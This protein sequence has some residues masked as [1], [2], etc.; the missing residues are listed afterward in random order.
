[1]LGRATHAY[2]PTSHDE[3]SLA[4]GDRCTEL[5]PLDDE[6]GWAS[7]VCASGSG[8][9]P[10]SHVALE[11][12][13][14]DDSWECVHR[15]FRLRHHLPLGA[16]S[17]PRAFAEEL[18]RVH[19]AA[20]ERRAFSAPLLLPPQAWPPPACD[21]ASCSYLVALAP[22]VAPY[23]YPPP[24]EEQFNAQRFA[25]M[26]L[27]WVARASRR[28]LVEPRFHLMPRNDT[29][30][31]RGHY[32][33]GALLGWRHEPATAFFNASALARYV[34]L[35]SHDAF[36]ERRGRAVDVLWRL[37]PPLGCA[38]EEERVQLQRLVGEDGLEAYGEGWR[39][40]A[41]R[42]TDG[43]RRRPLDHYFGGDDGDGGAGSAAAV[44]RYRRGWL[45]GETV[46]WPAERA[47]DYAELRA[48][49]VFRDE[50]RAAAAE[51]AA[52][53]LHGE[54]Y[55][56]VH[57]R[58]GDRTH[59]EMG[60]GGR[61]SYD[62]VAPPR[63]VRFVRR[64]LRRHPAARRVLLL[65]NSGEAAERAALRAALP[66]LVEYDPGAVGLPT[67][68]AHAQ[69]HSIVE[70][71][72]GSTADAFLAGPHHF[73]RLSTFARVVVEERELAG[74]VAGST[75]FMQP[76]ERLFAHV[77]YGSA[78]TAELVEGD[79]GVGRVGEPALHCVDCF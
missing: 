16:P 5:Q 46:T 30:V 19:A 18:R 48:H 23:A 53:R 24:H 77:E 41:Q 47:A 73:A 4:P 31:E 9:V 2:D 52:R 20:P 15:E 76:R 25:L 78:L 62:A 66:Q 33:D 17:T 12:S 45:F 21:Q 3:V 57:W 11:N 72:L 22:E 34:A 32:A 6:P 75:Y 59:P 35:A 26:E 7:A 44:W 14:S 36:V 40:R 70:Q 65:T 49:L 74:R 50:L 29:L 67:G 42:C 54:P 60:A 39:A 64:L 63:L 56:A 27:M 1:M 28:V 37:A 43:P 10:L 55:I 79:D 71:I 61:A 58:R 51:F 69:H 13:C 8:L 38:H 68:W